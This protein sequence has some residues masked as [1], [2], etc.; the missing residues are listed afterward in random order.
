MVQARQRVKGESEKGEVVLAQ[1]P[2]VYGM[3]VGDARVSATRRRL[4]GLRVRGW[5]CWRE[6][7]GNAKEGGMR[8][9]I[10]RDGV[11]EER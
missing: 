10:V 9:S 6:C 7:R 2:G 5:E 4:E 11:E 1:A 3:M 8:R